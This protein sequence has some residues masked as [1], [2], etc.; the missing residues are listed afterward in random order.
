MATGSRH[1]AAPPE[2]MDEDPPLTRLMSTHLVGITP[3]APLSAALQLMATRGVRHL[4]VIDGEGCRGVVLEVDLLRFIPHGFGSLDERAGPHVEDLIRPT[5]PLPVAARRSDA[6]HHMQAEHA[7]AVL[8]TDNGRLVG[9]VTATDLVRS[10]APAHPEH[11]AR[12]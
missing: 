11:R 6:A 7:D 12:P 3:D 1:P 9:I 8:V 4:P 2:T 10:L 5:Q